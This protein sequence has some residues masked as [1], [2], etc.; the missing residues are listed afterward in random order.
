MNMT[1]QVVEEYER[2][3][4]VREISDELSI[5]YKR[6][7]EIVSVKRRAGIITRPRAT[8]RRY[9]DEHRACPYC[10]KRV[11]RKIFDRHKRTH[12]KAFARVTGGTP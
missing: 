1:D 8:S 2:G 5:P 6:V 11:H 10:G 7:C 12:R 9:P 4:T 3:S